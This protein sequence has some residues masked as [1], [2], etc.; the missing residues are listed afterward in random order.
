MEDG[1]RSRLKKAF[2]RE[3]PLPMRRGVRKKGYLA[4]SKKLG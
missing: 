3:S 1:K 2:E 4:Y